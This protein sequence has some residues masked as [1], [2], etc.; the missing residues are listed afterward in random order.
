M[1]QEEQYDSGAEQNINSDKIIEIQ[2]PAGSQQAKPGTTRMTLKNKF[3]LI[4]SSTK[5]KL[6]KKKTIIIIN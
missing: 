1:E 3:D 4:V 6:N 2:I 5:T